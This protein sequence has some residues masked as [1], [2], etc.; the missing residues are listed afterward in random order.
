MKLKPPIPVFSPELKPVRR[1]AP[2]GPIILVSALLWGVL[3][4]TVFATY[5]FFTN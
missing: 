5:Y 4:W 1:I 2:A 3:A